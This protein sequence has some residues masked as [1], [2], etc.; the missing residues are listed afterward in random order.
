MTLSFI[1]VTYNSEDLIADCIKSIQKYADVPFENLEIVVVDNSSDE[2]FQKLTEVIKIVDTDIELTIIKNKNSGYGQGNNVG[3]NSAKGDLICVMNPD[4]RF[5]EPL[6]KDVFSKFEEDKSLCLLGYKQMGGANLSFYPKPEYYI[7]LISSLMVKVLNKLNLYSARY[8][9]LSGAFMFID[10]LKF[11]KV[12]MFDENI[13]LYYEEADISNR[14]KECDFRTKYDKN[15]SYLHLVG[16]RVSYSEFVFSNMLKS[17]AYYS[18]KYHLN[19]NHIC[20][21]TRLDYK[22]SIFIEKL[23]LRPNTSKIDKI[24]GELLFLE[25]FQNNMNDM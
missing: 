19:F 17:L 12:G 22:M 25:K 2:K 6:M 15:K 4:V 7:P 1:I 16:S 5:T 3:I 14:I 9:C 18:K 21:N 10:K 23:R 20:K 13:F 24:R 8:F 11:E